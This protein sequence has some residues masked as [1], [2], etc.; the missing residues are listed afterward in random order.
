M[1]CGE[2][3]LEWE[4][5]DSGVYVRT[6]RDR[7]RARR[8]VVTAGP[9]AEA[10]VPALASFAVPERLEEDLRRVGFKKDR[11]IDILYPWDNA[12]PS[13]KTGKFLVENSYFYELL[14]FIIQ[15]YNMLDGYGYKI[16]KK[17]ETRYEDKRAEG[18]EVKI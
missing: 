1:H 3:V 7:Y 8:L 13:L 9:W 10:L 14:G 6:N 12:V 4:A 16:L 5:D 17:Q 15:R 18:I 2:H 11:T